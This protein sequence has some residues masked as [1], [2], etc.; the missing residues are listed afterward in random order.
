MLGL[1]VVDKP[2][3]LTSHDVVA[4]VRRA[5]GIKR[6]GHTG[7]LDPF[8]TGVLVVCVGVATRLARYLEADRK[9]Y[10]A[11]VRLGASTTTYDCE[12]E[13]VDRGPVSV[14]RAELERALT[15]FRG[16]IHQVPPM[17]SAKSVGGVRLHALARRGVEVARAPVAIHID[18]LE[19]L[20]L[21]D[22]GFD[23]D[24]ACSKGTYV[25]ALAHDLGRALGTHAH[26]AALDRTGCGVFTKADATPL[27]DLV[28]RPAVERH[29]RSPLDGMPTMPRRE[30]DAR[31]A[32]DFR[33][34]K[35]VRPG[36]RG[37]DLAPGAAVAAL[38]AATDA[39]IGIGRVRDDGALAPETVLA[40]PVPSRLTDVS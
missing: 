32:A 5:A 36:A 23:L 15:A 40:T 21:E 16:P 6:V 35:A 26:L 39:L 17:F 33:Q 2:A 22:D 20:S 25:R 1:L 24:I 3:G 34:G 11:R 27:A 14:T 12:G 4:R 18:T 19:L 9:R 38:V 30:L 31:L 13:V 28:D 8:A 37:A 7:T 29:L 10:L